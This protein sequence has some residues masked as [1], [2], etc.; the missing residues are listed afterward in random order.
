VSDIS[1]LA[2]DRPVD[3]SSITESTAT[4]GLKP[5]LGGQPDHPGSEVPG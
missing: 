3:S 1:V 4:S 2:P 5:V